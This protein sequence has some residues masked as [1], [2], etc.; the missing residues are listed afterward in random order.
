[1]RSH[2][3]TSLT[4]RHPP[5][6]QNGFTLIELLIV[7]VILGLLA[8][9]VAPQLFDKVGSSKIQVAKTQTN[10]LATAIDSY[11]LDVGRPPESLTQLEKSDLPNW[12]GPYLRDGLPQDPWGHA[13]IYRAG[14]R[15]AG[16]LFEIRS[17]GADAK[18]G[19]NDDNADIVKRG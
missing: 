10:M 4:A 2:C 18:E 3:P 13:Y 9:L 5:Q 12:R 14:N 16:F 6:R 1:M 11:M 17:L 8:S 19:G 15:E 7:M